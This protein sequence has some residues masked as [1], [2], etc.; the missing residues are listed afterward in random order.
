MPL[1]QGLLELLCDDT[2]LSHLARSIHQQWTELLIPFS[3]HLDIDHSA[4]ERCELRQ[5]PA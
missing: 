4:N 5:M 3:N 2:V 1:S